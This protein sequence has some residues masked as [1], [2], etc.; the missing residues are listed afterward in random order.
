MLLIKKPHQIHVMNVCFKKYLRVNKQKI[1]FKNVE[2]FKFFS[3]G[4]M[5][6]Y[7]SNVLLFLKLLF[8]SVF[9]SQ[10]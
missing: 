4:F 5:N 9:S 10:I 8:S 7:I 2:L 6:N 1:A 3:L